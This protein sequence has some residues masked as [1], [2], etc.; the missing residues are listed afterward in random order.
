MSTPTRDDDHVGEGLAFLTGRFRDKVTL[1]AFLTAGLRQIQLS[2]DMM[3]D[4]IAAGDL[5]TPPTGQALDQIADMVGA[6][7]GSFNDA[8]LLVFTKV[9]IAARKSGG[10]AEDLIQLLALVVSGF[11]Y[12]DWYPAAF[13]IF[14]PNIPAAYAAP[15]AIALNIARP[16]AV[17]GTFGY[18]NWPMSETLYFGDSTGSMVGQGFADSVSGMFPFKLASSV[19]V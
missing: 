15:L 18:T 6:K 8:Q 12:T 7:R 14:A 1:R 19:Q 17:Y 4:V 16:P 11:T 13:Q 2:E 9:F 10:R 3:W 5:S